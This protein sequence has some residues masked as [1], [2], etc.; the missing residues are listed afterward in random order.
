[1][2]SA[3]FSQVVATCSRR[4]ADRQAARADRELDRVIS[5]QANGDLELARRLGESALK[6]FPDHVP[7]RHVLGVICAQAREFAPAL[8]HLQHAAE[9][10]PQ[11]APA[12]I[13]LGNVHRL[14]GRNDAA[15]GCYRR[16]LE[17]D[18]ASAMAHHNLGLAL[19]DLEE[20]SQAVAHLRR[21]CE[22]SD[23]ARQPLE[24]LA[25]ALTGLNE[26]DEA[27]AV[28]QDDRLDASNPQINACKG[29]VYQKMHEPAL[30]LEHYG[31]AVAGGGRDNA[32]LMN[33]LG[34]VMQELGR[35]DEALA[36]NSRALELDPDFPGARFHR[37]AAYLLKGD[38]ERGWADYDARL[39]GRNHEARRPLAPRWQGEPLKG[40]TVL[41][42]NEQGLGD[43]IMFASC[44]PDLQ[45]EGG[46]CLL[47]CDR[48]LQPLFARSFPESRVFAAQPDRSIP[49]SVEAIPDYE[50][51]A[52]SLPVRY[53]RNDADFP[54]KAGYLVAD[55]NAVRAWSERLAGL[56][57]GLKVG[58]SWRGGTFKTRQPKRS[59]RP[60]A[61]SSM[62]A[63]PGVQFVS[64][65]YGD[66]AADLVE[67]GAIE[68]CSLTHWQEAIDDYEQT[69]ALVSALDLVISV[70]TAVIHLGGALGRPVWVMA[71]YSPEWRYGF[72]GERMIW[73]PSVRMF[74]QPEYGAWQEVVERV[75][76]ALRMRVA[77]RSEDGNG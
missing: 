65:Q 45:R 44:M 22:L 21:A 46:Q 5:A 69:A 64:L 60:A 74:R 8:T 23:D 55:D 7:L 49:A 50:I 20:F 17:L 40:K 13:D 9:R 76:G 53:R 70:C 10:S 33:N 38:F 59:L 48:R 27:L 26:F 67:F 36:Y 42:F 34:I 43:E 52:G 58:I 15:I 37:A 56:G 32:E 72:S 18:P 4:A 39:R 41:V 1:M 19:K 68:G 51:P 11:F 12:H 47:E 30:A 77:G 62:L 28:L 29:F 31:V 3:L 71:P 25:L 14:Q 54:S 63:T 61:L 16:A 66:V 73:Y 24:D 6:R 2:L 57:S 35:I 75:G